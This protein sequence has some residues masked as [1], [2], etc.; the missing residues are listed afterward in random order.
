[1]CVRKRKRERE[2]ER[3]RER[4]G[5]RSTTELHL[6]PYLS[7]LFGSFLSAKFLLLRISHED[8]C[9]SEILTLTTT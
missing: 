4:L 5:R 8:M 7:V 2:R 3:E 1:M 9:N 6:Q